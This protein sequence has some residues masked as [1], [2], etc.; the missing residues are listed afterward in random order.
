MAPGGPYALTLSSVL[1]DQATEL[2]STYLAPSPTGP[3]RAAEKPIGPT[4]Q[5]WP[6]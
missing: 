5:F 1:P 2:H 4:E 6:T 3:Q